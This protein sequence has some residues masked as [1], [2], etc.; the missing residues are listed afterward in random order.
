MSDRASLQPVICLI[1]TLPLIS[2]SVSPLSS[3]PLFPFMPPI[4][5]SIYF[6]FPVSPPSIFSSSCASYLVSNPPPLSFSLPHR[7]QYCIRNEGLCYVRSNRGVWTRSGDVE[8]LYSSVKG[9]IMYES[10]GH[11]TYKVAC[12]THMCV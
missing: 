9:A 5:L 8:M 2:M 10:R 3:C 4:L 6:P 11:L 12:R 1:F 7:S